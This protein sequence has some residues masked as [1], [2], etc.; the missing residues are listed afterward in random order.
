MANLRRDAGS[1]YME[2][3]KLCSASRHN[4]ATSGMLSLSLVDL[5][6]RIEQLELNGPGGYRYTPLLEG[7]SRTYRGPQESIISA[8]GMSMANYLALAAPTE[9]GDQVLIE[10]PGYEPLV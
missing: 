10:R 7:I 4:L 5:P 8:S 1:T 2:W 3:A 9:P 6:V